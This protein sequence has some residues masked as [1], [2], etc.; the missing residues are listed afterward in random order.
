MEQPSY[1]K[2]TQ[3]RFDYAKAMTGKAT[4]NAKFLIDWQYVLKPNTPYFIT[5]S[6]IYTNGLTLYTGDNPALLWVDFNTNVYKATASGGAKTDN[7]L[8]VILPF[9]ERPQGQYVVFYADHNSNHPSYM[10]KRPNNNMVN[11]KI[12]KPDG[13]LWDDNDSLDPLPPQQWS[14]TFQFTEAEH[15]Y[16]RYVG[17]IQRGVSAVKPIKKLYLSQ[18]E[19]TGTI[20]QRTYN[21]DMDAILDRNK[22][23]KVGFVFSGG[24]PLSG[25]SFPSLFLNITW[26]LDTAYPFNNLTYAS[27]Y[28]ILGVIGKERYDTGTGS[29]YL[30]SRATTNEPV[31]LINWGNNI[32]VSVL[33]S[34]L[35]LYTNMPGSNNRWVLML[36][37]E[38]L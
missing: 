38:E 36:A 26:N 19:G 22:Q 18:N 2:I 30:Q 35:N 25:S 24:K 14:I 3:V 32:V 23:Y 21:V 13:D 34:N 17:S 29:Y 10:D 33:D 5:F 11:I 31:S 7:I 20:A 28:G 37:F 4:N 1:K 15:M 16:K 27:Q 9:L 8:G 12:L 6:F